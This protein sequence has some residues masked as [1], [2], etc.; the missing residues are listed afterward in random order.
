MSVTTET[1]AGA[2]AVHPFRVDIPQEAVDDLRSRIASTRLPERETV[3]DQSQ[4]VRLATMQELMRYW[5]SG[6]DWRRCEG[7]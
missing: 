6:Y 5:G 2:T 3:G 1:R 4:G 7:S